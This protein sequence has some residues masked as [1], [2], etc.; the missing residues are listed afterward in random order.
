MVIWHHRHW[1]FPRNLSHRPNFWV[2]RHLFNL[3]SIITV[4]F[5][6]DCLLGSTCVWQGR[7]RP[8]E[9]SAS[10][11]ATMTVKSW[12]YGYIFSFL[13]KWGLCWAYYVCIC[14]QNRKNDWLSMIF[15]GLQ[16]FFSRTRGRPTYQPP[17]RESRSGAP[18]EWGGK[19]SMGLGIILVLFW[20]WMQKPTK[21]VF[22]RPARHLRGV[23]G[24]GGKNPNWW[25]HISLYRHVPDYIVGLVQPK[26][27]K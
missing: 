25:C 12:K 18:L 2:L 9:A 1:C 15:G 6:L 19:N 11:L 3:L 27:L 13:H 10:L 20:Y 17:V 26:W 5:R 24:F 16:F 7:T 4:P 21:T 14:T 23:R 8:R 22:L